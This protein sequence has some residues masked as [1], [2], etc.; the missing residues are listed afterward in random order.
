M[1]NTDERALTITEAASVALTGG[2]MA[3][4]LANMSN[5]EFAGRLTALERS[6]DRMKQ[7]Q[8]KLMK[9]NVDYGRIP[10]TGDKPTLLKA[11][12][13]TLLQFYQLVPTFETY[14]ERGD[15]VAS[16]HIRYHVK[17]LLHLSTSDGPVVG[18]GEG[19]AN[20]SEKKYRY[21][22]ADRA[23]PDCGCLKT[24]IRGKPEFERDPKFQGGWLCFDKKGG[25]GAKFTP[26]DPRIVSQQLSMVENPDPDDMDN[27]L[28]K[29]AEKRSQI[30]GT[31]RATATSGLF[32]QD[33]ED[34]EVG[35]VPQGASPPPAA[36][37]RSSN[38]RT[39]ASAPGEPP[40]DP[41]TSE[42][43]PNE[44][45][46]IGPWFVTARDSLKE[47]PWA[48]EVITR[49]ATSLAISLGK[50]NLMSDAQRHQMYVLLTGKEH[51]AEMDPRELYLLNNNSS[52]QHVKRWL[53]WLAW[54]EAQEAQ[55]P[56]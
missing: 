3:Q 44:P 6:Q 23:C 28:L 33:I 15:G 12:S 46:E 25:C 54:Y 29:I 16:P 41:S 13:E 11:G 45:A 56:D 51:G 27:T 4:M 31:L 35:A 32:T 50:G 18:W 20:S 38:H 10:G 7:I 26:G 42:H 53:V 47:L 48:P 2:S 21:R 30:D 34:M 22:T 1:T 40:S 17:C 52:A 14:L 9:E 49:S 8:R 5:E 55:K 43:M 39:G 19:S 36:P 24:I 37:T